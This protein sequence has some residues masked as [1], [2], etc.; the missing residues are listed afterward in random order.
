MVVLVASWGSKPPAA[1][2]CFRRHWGAKREAGAAAS[3]LDC[4]S[5]C[6][7]SGP[8]LPAK[9]DVDVDV[10]AAPRARARP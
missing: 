10:D 7:E 5:C 9:V 8:P 3:Q 1:S 2:S 6:V 4:R